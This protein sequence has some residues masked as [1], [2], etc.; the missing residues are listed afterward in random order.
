MVFFLYQPL[1]QAQEDTSPLPYPKMGFGLPDNFNET[2]KYRVD[3]G[4]FLFQRTIGGITSERPRFMSETAYRQWMFN[5]QIQ[6]YWKQKVQSGILDEGVAGTKPKFEMGESL[7]RIFGG[8]TIDIRPQGSAQ[9]TFSGNAD[10]TKNPNLTKNQQSNASFNFDQSIQM[11]VIG[12]IGTK[13]ALR[14]NYDTKSQFDFENQMKLEYSGD[15]DQIIKKIELGNVSLPLSGSLISGTQSLFGVK[16]QFQFGKA[17][18][19]TVFSEQKSETST[20]RVDGGAQTTNFEIYA[21]DYEANKHFFL[22]QYFYENYDGALKN[23]PIINSNVTITNIEV[24]VT[25]RSGVTQNVRNVLAFQDLG[26]NYEDVYNTSNVYAG[27]LN[28]VNPDNKNNSL[29]PAL[30]VSDFPNIRNVSKITTE[31]NG[32]GYEQSVDYEKIENA[33]KLTR[34]EYS[35]DARLGFISLNQALNSDEILAVAFQYTYNGVPYQVG[36]LSTDVASPDALV[37]KLLKST[38]VDVKLPLWKLSM[39]NVYSLGAYQVNKEDFD[40]QI[41]YQDDESGTPIPFVPEGGMSSS[42]LIQLMNLDNLNQNN[43]PGADGVFDFIPNLTVKTSNGRVYLPST[44]PFGDYLRSKFQEAGLAD[45]ISNQYVFDALYDSTKTAASQMA[46]LNKFMIRGKYKSS[47]GSDIPL[48]AMDVP[49]GSVTVS[50]GGTPL[51]EG[52]HY[53]VDYNLG[54]VKIIDEGILSSGQAIDVK[55]ES[56]S[57]Y[58]WMTKRYLGLHAD[59]KFNDDLIVGATLLNLSEN[60]QTPK[61]NMG[62]EPISNTIWGINGSY[63][64]DAPIL[65]R[66]VDKLPFIQTKEKS[67]VLFSGEFAQF[68]P[69]H[70]KS[71]NVDATGTAYIDDFENSQS[72]IDL[73][74]APAWSLASTPQDTDLFPEATR[75]NDLS[76]GCN[77]ALLSWYTIN[78]DLQRKTSYSPRHITDE[79]REAPYARE[80]TINEIFPDKDIPH[81][82]SLCDYALLIWPFILRKEDLTILMYRVKREFHLV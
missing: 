3:E 14:T 63:K 81:G 76:Y 2:I 74:S 8:N 47:S 75:T 66:L 39:K 48:N 44:E 4:D 52:I 43:D 58:S 51:E 56:N 10:R 59:Y 72:P 35:F 36:E 15:E 5:K 67:N 23:M 34:S 27:S 37:L 62:D 25:N 29:D 1:V 13:L 7:G 12:K 26:E 9:L 11:N 6:S 50:M 82:Q 80:I 55:L 24:W 31:L 79:D 57:A 49:K 69:G 73:R 19:T 53:T 21:D 17:T 54:R 71:I 61:I 22:G 70:P 18:F 46:E 45:A 68:I 20:I 33:K 77:R 32:S 40:L 38:S 60:S 42:L 30:L 65:T 78:S 28:V 64:T 41:L 16:A